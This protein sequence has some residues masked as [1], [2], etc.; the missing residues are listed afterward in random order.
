MR[1]LYYEKPHFLFWSSTICFNFVAANCG[2]SWQHSVTIITFCRHSQIYF[3]VFYKLFSGSCVY[4]CENTYQKNT[5][6]NRM[7]I[8]ILF[9]IS[10][11]IIF[12]YQ[13]W[14]WNM[15]KYFS[16][17]CFSEKGTQVLLYSII[18]NIFLSGT[19]YRFSKLNH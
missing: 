7:Q 15:R 4:V 2:G 8:T 6:E 1:Q 3:Y 9:K 10:L 18:T 14:K 12:R 17:I 13:V 19:E 16:G 11:I 5:S